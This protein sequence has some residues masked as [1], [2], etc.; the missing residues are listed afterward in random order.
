MIPTILYTNSINYKQQTITQTFHDQVSCMY[1][2]LCLCGKCCILGEPI[3]DYFDDQ[4][5]RYTY[6]YIILQSMGK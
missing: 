1:Q 4:Y 6:L 2:Y 5:N 3:C